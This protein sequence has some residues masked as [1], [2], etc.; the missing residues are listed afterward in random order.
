MKFDTDE[1]WVK[2]REEKGTLLRNVAAHEIGHI[3]G[4]SHSSVNSALMAPYYDPNVDR[5]QQ[6]DD[7]T[8][9]QQLYGVK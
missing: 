9:I 1:I 5:P 3:L 8:R 7:V 2:N 6:N 4:L